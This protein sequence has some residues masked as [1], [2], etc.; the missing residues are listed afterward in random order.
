[1]AAWCAASRWV[2]ISRATPAR[3]AYDITSIYS[4]EHLVA[5]LNASPQL[6]VPGSDLAVSLGLDTTT[7]YSRVMVRLSQAYFTMAFNSP[8]SSVDFF[9][10][11]VTRQM[12]E[13]FT[14]EGNPLAWVPS[15]TY[16]R[17]YVIL[18][19]SE[20]TTTRLEAAVKSASGEGAG[21]ASAQAKVNADRLAKEIDGERRVFE[22]RVKSIEAPIKERAHQ[23]ETLSAQLSAAL[24]QGQEL[25]VKAIEGA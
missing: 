24:K 22:L 16:G 11:E 7:T 18:F 17:L 13:P 25:A 14:Q 8:A 4:K 5:N 9:H 15:V 12:L 23:I 6:A 10:N 2:R 21:I 20:D 19:E 1:M 3:V